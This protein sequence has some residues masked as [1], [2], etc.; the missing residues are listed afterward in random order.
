MALYRYLQP[1]DT[2]PDPNGHLSSSVGPSPIK[3][4]N[5]AVRSATHTTTPRVRYAKFTPEQQAAI[6]EYAFLTARQ[7]GGYP[8]FCKAVELKVSLGQTWKRNYQ[9]EIS[10]K[11]KAVR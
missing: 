11:R 5:K 8:S 6:G 10:R 7:P 4:A 3:D 9:A 2:L 1:V